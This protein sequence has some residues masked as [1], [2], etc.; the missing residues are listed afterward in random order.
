MY[1]IAWCIR[2]W[3]SAELSRY[4]GCG[5]TTSKRL[6]STFALIHSE[7]EQVLGINGLAFGALIILAGFGAYYA[8]GLSRRPRSQAQPQVMGAEETVRADV[9]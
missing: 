6:P 1:S 7:H 9:A 4:Y 8:T 3:K 5:R 2:S